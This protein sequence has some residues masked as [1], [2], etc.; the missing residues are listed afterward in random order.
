MLERRGDEFITLPPKEPIDVKG[1]E[2]VARG[3]FG[4]PATPKANGNGD[5]PAPLALA[6]SVPAGPQPPPPAPPPPAEQPT[7][8]PPPAKPTPAPKAS[9]P[10]KGCLSES[11]LMGSTEEKADMARIREEIRSSPI[12]RL[13]R[14][15]PFL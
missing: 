14:R 15:N 4:I 1:L 11:D 3:L 9:A 12:N 8:A 10:P 13:R 7:K 6:A 5:S 2:D